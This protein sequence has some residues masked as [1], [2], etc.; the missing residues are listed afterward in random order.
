[1]QIPTNQ[2][3]TRIVIVISDQKIFRQQELLGKQNYTLFKYKANHLKISHK[4]RT[5]IRIVG[6]SQESST[7]FV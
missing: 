5:R 4:K 6:L 1:M 7:S 3:K 2:R